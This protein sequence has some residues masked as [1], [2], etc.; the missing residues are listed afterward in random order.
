MGVQVI[1]SERRKHTLGY[2]V[3]EKVVRRTTSPTMTISKLGRLSFNAAAAETL[4]KS[5]VEYVL[6]LW[7][8]DARKVAVRSTAKKDARAYTIR[9]AAK[10][11]L[12]GFAAKTFLNH[13]QYDFTT[14][15]QY[16]C[17]WDEQSE[18]YEVQLPPERFNAQ[19]P[20]RFPRLEQGGK[21]PSEVGRHSKASA[22][23]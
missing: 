21:K 3:Y 18:M 2:E 12:A 23:A 17:T 8:K 19:E 1:P 16:P 22:I 15:N 13:I 4:H 11:K 10:Y 7:D 20:R 6:L 5:A 9:Y 14:T